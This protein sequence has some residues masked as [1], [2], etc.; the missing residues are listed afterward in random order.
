MDEFSKMIERDS[1]KYIDLSWNNMKGEYS[2]IL[3]SKFSQCERLEHLDLSQNL[4]GMSHG[5][6]E[7]AVF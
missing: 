4:L 2:K 5:N 1:L 3:A 7:P 6:E